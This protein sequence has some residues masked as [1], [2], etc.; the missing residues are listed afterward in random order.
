M[1]RTYDK[2][3]YYTIPKTDMYPGLVARKVDETHD[4]VALGEPSE[5][6]KA[7][8]ASFEAKY[9]GLPAG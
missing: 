3:G 4:L 9:G 6:R 7:V 5:A 8:D 2:D 1:S